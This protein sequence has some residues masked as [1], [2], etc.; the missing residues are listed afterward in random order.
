V[1]LYAAEELRVFGEVHGEVVFL[2][3]GLATRFFWNHPNV[4][5]TLILDVHVTR[6]LKDRVRRMFPRFFRKEFPK[7]VRIC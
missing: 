3:V 4:G 5:H 2:P 7:A 1:R 6:E